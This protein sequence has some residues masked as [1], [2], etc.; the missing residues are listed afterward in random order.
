MCYELKEYVSHW[1]WGDSF[2]LSPVC[3]QLFFSIA[4]VASRLYVAG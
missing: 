3:I 2:I 4:S 1:I